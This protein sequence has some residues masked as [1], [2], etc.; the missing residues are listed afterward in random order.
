CVKNTAFEHK[1]QKENWQGV[2]SEMDN[3]Q[4]EDSRRLMKGVATA[5]QLKQTENPAQ[6]LST[7][8]AEETSN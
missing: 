3:A 4:P 5:T 1:S 7:A 2:N 8:P 6:A